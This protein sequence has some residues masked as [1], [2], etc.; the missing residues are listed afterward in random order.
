MKYGTLI[1][2]F[3]FKIALLNIFGKFL[4]KHQQQSSHLA[5]FSAFNMCSGINAFIGI[6]Q[7]FSQWLFQ[8]KQLTGCFSFRLIIP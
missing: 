8:R 5:K 6:F 3:S 4:E 2:R 1:G 7:E